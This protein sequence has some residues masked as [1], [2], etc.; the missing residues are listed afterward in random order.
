MLN[1][2]AFGA[3]FLENIMFFNNFPIYHYV[4]ILSPW[5]GVIYDPREFIWT[6]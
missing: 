3:A 2:I 5:N 6:I 1:M 4:E